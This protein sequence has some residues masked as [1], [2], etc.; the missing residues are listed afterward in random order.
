MHYPYHFLKISMHLHRLSVCCGTKKEQ[1][2]NRGV[3]TKIFECGYEMD[4]K[5]DADTTQ[6]SKMVLS[7]QG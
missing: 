6:G 3:L 2:G 4:T 5:M 7:D 1:G